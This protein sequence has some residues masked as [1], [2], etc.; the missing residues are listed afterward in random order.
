MALLFHDGIVSAL[1]LVSDAEAG[2]IFKEVG[3]MKL[4]EGYQP[5]KIDGLLLAVISSINMADKKYEEKKRRTSEYYK[6]KKAK[7][8]KE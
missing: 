3:K 8:V 7:N 5:K 1:L 4:E 2:R 6:N